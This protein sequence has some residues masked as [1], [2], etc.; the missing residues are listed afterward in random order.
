[1]DSD[2]AITAA[3]GLSFLSYYSAAVEM[4]SAEAVV[5]AATMAADAAKISLK[6]SSGF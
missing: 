2:L 3:G 5:A 1:M 4:V 6:N